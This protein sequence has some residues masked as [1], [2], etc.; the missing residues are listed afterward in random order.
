MFARIFTLNYNTGDISTTQFD[1]DCLSWTDCYP[2]FLL[3]YTASQ[4]FQSILIPATFGLYHFRNVYHINEHH[5]IR[6][7]RVSDL[8]IQILRPTYHQKCYFCVIPYFR[9]KLFFARANP[10]RRIDRCLVAECVCSLFRIHSRVHR[11]RAKIILSSKFQIRAL[12][13]Y[14]Q[15]LALDARVR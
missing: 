6:S 8:S 11:R 4:V 13:K 1:I 9:L 14:K 10:F 3:N 7:V 15:I 2:C 12:P 5:E